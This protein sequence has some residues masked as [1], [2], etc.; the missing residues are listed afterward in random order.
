MN[1]HVA[2]ASGKGGTGKTTIAANLAFLWARLGRQVLYVDCDVEAPNGH[3]FLHP[4]IEQ[5]LPA[6]T[7]VPQIAKDL[8]GLCGRCGSFCHYNALLCLPD[9]VLT[10]PELCHGCGG[11]IRLCPHQAISEVPREIGRI[12]MGTAGSVNFASGLL[13]IGE[14]MSPPLIRSLKN[15][16][17]ESDLTIIDAPPGTSCPVIE[18]IRHCDYTLLVTEPTPFGLNDLQL[19][20]EMLRALDQPFGVV[21]NRA[22]LD[23]RPLLDYCL[24]EQ[25]PILA[26]LP[27]DRRV[28]EAYSRGELVCS[29]L[30]DFQQLF[31][32][33]LAAV[34][35]VLQQK[36]A[37]L[38]TGRAS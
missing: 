14:A 21:I 35:M 5:R 22:G 4:K 29:V 8:C 26:Q 32:A 13:N 27:D 38:T 19:A 2:I 16:L 17:I 15:S 36:K 18:S 30:T 24:K 20:V 11:C 28:A 31:A 34:D 23:D 3:I 7:T 6:T 12:E 10:F 33:L 25:L 9:Q 1:Q 37:N